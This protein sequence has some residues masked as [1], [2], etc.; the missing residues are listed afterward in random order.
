[1]D[2]KTVRRSAWMTAA[3]A[4]FA[5]SL[6]VAQDA[7][8][9]EQSQ[10][11]PAEKQNDSKDTKGVERSRPSGATLRRA[12]PSEITPAMREAAR[13]QE[14]AEQEKGAQIL[15]DDLKDNQIHP[16]AR[17]SADPADSPFT[18]ST[19]VHDWGMIDDTAR[20]SFTFSFTNTS[21]KPFSIRA[22]GSCGC[23][24]PQLAKTSYLPGESG[25]ITVEFN[26]AGRRGAQTQHVNIEYTN[27]PNTP[28]TR[29]T[30]QS[31][32]RPIVML[33]PGRTNLPRVDYGVGHTEE[34]VVTSRDP[35]LQILSATSDNPNVTVV[36]GQPGETEFEGEPALRIPVSVS[37]V[38]NAPL[39]KLGATISF[40]TN[41]PRVRLNPHVVS[42]HVYGD[43][44]ATPQTLRIREGNPNTP[45]DAEIR[46]STTSGRSFNIIGADVETS[47]PMSIAVDFETRKVDGV[48]ATFVTLIGTTPIA[49]GS[50]TGDLIVKTDIDGGLEMRI[51]FYAVVR[52]PQSAMR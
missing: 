49:F 41:S 52:R 25:E 2:W 26:P 45:F 5:A 46:L 30:V 6:V 9:G 16:A 50:T 1:M 37:I 35:S 34:L 40:E 43:L 11:K 38:P 10:I 7:K 39:G 24:V 3:V 18:W 44:E 23:T 20:K 14:Q 31:N 12:D 33:D 8:P 42:A 48:D 17:F 27:S 19:M 51:P 21:D 36:L 28:Q 4:G 32:I 15:N 22:R 13:R 29:L 47:R